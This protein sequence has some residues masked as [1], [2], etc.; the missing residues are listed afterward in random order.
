M[1]C[2]ATE[3]YLGEGGGLTHTSSWRSDVYHAIGDR[4]GGFVDA[5][6][7]SGDLGVV[8]L[9]V[10]C[11]GH[12]PL[13]VLVRWASSTFSIPIWPETEPTMVSDTPSRGPMGGLRLEKEGRD[14]TRDRRNWRRFGDAP[15]L[16]RFGARPDFQ[17]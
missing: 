1:L 11:N 12:V 4:C 5:D 10:R 14:W 13:R 15:N 17:R 3:G 16:Q 6:E 9:C 2:Q 7:L 8:Q